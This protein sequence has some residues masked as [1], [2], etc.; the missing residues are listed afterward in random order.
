MQIQLIHD[1]TTTG[2]IQ[3]QPQFLTI[4]HYIRII[5]LEE[6]SWKVLV[7]KERRRRE[8]QNCWGFWGTCRIVFNIDEA[9]VCSISNAHMHTRDNI[10]KCLMQ[11]RLHRMPPPPFAL[12]QLNCWR[13]GPS[14]SEKRFLYFCQMM[15][16]R[17][18]TYCKDVNNLV[19]ACA[20]SIASF[21]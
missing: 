13:W 14:A 16:W 15:S 20:H 4:K 21:R 3:T 17:K 19:Y 10:D 7:N 11:T 12:S 2:W 6:Q 1:A 5:I 9:L 8:N 18:K